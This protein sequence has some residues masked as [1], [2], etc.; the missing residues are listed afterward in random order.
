V[1]LTTQQMKTM[2]SIDELIQEAE[3]RNKEDEDRF[4]QIRYKLKIM[5]FTNILHRLDLR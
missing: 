3:K 2:F 5:V 1:H 4:N